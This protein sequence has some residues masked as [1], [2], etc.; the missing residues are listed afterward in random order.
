MKKGDIVIGQNFVHNKVYNGMEGEIVEDLRYRYW[1]IV[2][3]GAGREG[4]AYKVLWANGNLYTQEPFQL[5]KKK[6][7]NKDIELTRANPVSWDE[8]LWSPEHEHHLL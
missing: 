5:R 6:P 4:Y 2:S 7:P 3:T 1:H 8:C